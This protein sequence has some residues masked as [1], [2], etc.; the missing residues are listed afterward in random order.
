MES[1]RNQLANPHSHTHC[2]AAQAY[3]KTKAF[4]RACKADPREKKFLKMPNR[5]TK[6][7]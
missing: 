2:Q 3:T 6:R 4:K 1:N 5:T 7:Q